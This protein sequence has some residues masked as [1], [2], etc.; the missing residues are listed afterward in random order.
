MLI[1]LFPRWYGCTASRRFRRPCERPGGSSGRRSA[2]LL[3]FG[4]FEWTEELRPRVYYRG[5][6]ALQKHQLPGEVSR[7]ILAF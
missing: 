2:P 4:S 5:S 3:D 7:A 6:P 1:R